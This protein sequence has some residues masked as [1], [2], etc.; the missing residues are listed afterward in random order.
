VT[1]MVEIVDRSLYEDCESSARQRLISR[2]VDDWPIVA[3]ALILKCPIWTENQDFFGSGISTW[4]T[5][6]VELYLRDA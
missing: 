6:T 2:D 3:T 4:T 5:A 1:R